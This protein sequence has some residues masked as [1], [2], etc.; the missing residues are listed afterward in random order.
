MVGVENGT[1]HHKK[2]GY[3]I[4]LERFLDEMFYF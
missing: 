4:S 1:I 3:S 2:G